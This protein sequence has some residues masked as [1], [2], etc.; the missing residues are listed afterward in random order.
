M[1]LGGEQEVENVL[2]KRGDDYWNSWQ[3]WQG[4]LEEWGLVG[5]SWNPESVLDDWRLA[6]RVFIQPAAPGSLKIS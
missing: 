5:E 4:F 2:R 1:R 3:G 6:T